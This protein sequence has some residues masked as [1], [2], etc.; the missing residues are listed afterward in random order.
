MYSMP[1]HAVT[2]GY[3]KMEY[4]RAH[5]MASSSREVKKLP[6]P[7]RALP[8]ARCTDSRASG[9]P[10]TPASRR[11][12]TSPG[13]GTA[14]PQPQEEQLDV[15]DD[16]QDRDRRELDRKAPLAHR[17][18][19]LAALERREL[20]RRQPPGRDEQRDAEQRA[21]HAR[22]EGESQQDGQVFH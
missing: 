2:N 3:W 19:I 8:Y 16:E 4:L 13:G 15:E 18:R 21:R 6:T 1:Q 5:P 7:T 9:W 10:G 11:S 17:D 12:R 22:R 14:S 20:H